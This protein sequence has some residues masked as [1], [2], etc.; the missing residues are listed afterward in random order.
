MKVYVTRNGDYN[1]ILLSTTV[2]KRLGILPGE[3]PKVNAEK[4]TNSSE[5]PQIDDYSLQE[6][7][8]IRR[9]ELLA[10]KEKEEDERAKDPLGRS[11]AEILT[12]EEC[13]KIKQWAITECPDVFK[14]ILGKTDRLKCEW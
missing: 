3:F 6:E 2:M 9:L 13:K 7:N 4:F 5:D 10:E 11:K 1:E 14:S 12:D 8:T